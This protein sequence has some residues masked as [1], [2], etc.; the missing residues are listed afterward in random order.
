MRILPTRPPGSRRIRENGLTTFRDYTRLIQSD[1]V[2][3]AAMIVA[4]TTNHTSF[5]RE[6]H[7]YEHFVAHAWPPLDQRLAMNSQDSQSGAKRTSN[8]PG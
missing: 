2:E 4:L 3:R 1:P 6:A 8:R 7:H 5:F